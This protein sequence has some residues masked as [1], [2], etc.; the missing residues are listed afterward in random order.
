MIQQGE[1][2]RL[3]GR[4]DGSIAILQAVRPD[5]FSEIRASKIQGL[6]ERADMQVRE[7]T[8]SNIQVPIQK[9][10]RSTKLS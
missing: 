4:F 6:A 2:L 8:P 9:F 5:G 3:L 1:L 7:L 10:P